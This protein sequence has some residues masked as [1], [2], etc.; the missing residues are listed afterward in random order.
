M[1]MKPTTQKAEGLLNTPGLSQGEKQFLQSILEFL[2]Q[3]KEDPKPDVALAARKWESSLIFR[4]RL[5][6]SRR[7]QSLATSGTSPR[8]GKGK[9]YGNAV[10][11]L[12]G[13]Q[14]PTEERK[15]LTLTLSPERRGEKFHVSLLKEAA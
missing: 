5:S 2:E 3:A 7:P 14:I 10:E 12:A 8:R 13:G 1:N 11:A 15:H 6:L 4:I 9:N